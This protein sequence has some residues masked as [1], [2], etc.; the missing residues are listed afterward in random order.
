L[1]PILAI[2]KEDED[3]TASPLPRGY[4]LIEKLLECSVVISTLYPDLL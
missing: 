4:H 1:M 3:I 2:V